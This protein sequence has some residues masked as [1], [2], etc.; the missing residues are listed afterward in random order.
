MTQFVPPLTHQRLLHPQKNVIFPFLPELPI[1]SFRVAEFSKFARKPPISRVKVAPKQ[2]LKQIEESMLYRSYSDAFTQLS[3][4]PLSLVDSDHTKPCF[5]SSS[6]NISQLC[7]QIQSC[8][9]SKH[10]CNASNCH[11]HDEATRLGHFTD[12]CFGGLLL[13]AIPIRIG[14]ETI[15][16]LK[17]G[18]VLTSPPTE[19]QFQ[20]MVKVLGA[21]A[22]DHDTISKL[23]TAYFQTPTIK[24]TNYEASITLLQYFAEQLATHATNLQLLE[25]NSEL[26][27]ISRAKAFIKENLSE[28]L[29]LQS[30][31]KQV[32]LSSSHFSRLFRQA[33]GFTLTDYIN[34][35]RIDHAKSLLLHPNLRVSEIAFQIGYQSLSQFNRSF[36][37]IVGCPPSQWRTAKMKNPVGF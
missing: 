12:H 36:S 4:M 20:K 24:P 22:L 1:L 27:T 26:E 29:S 17:T 23:H 30:I 13:S 19:F 14:Q 3:G 28:D 35:C 25:D 21:K 5:S 33:T 16:F 6:S 15:G 11:V 31:A 32:H 37:R 18:Q 7:S 9:D 10:S 8:P 34:R 2:L